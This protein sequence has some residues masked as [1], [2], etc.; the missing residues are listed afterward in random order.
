[1]N[2]SSLE[3]EQMAVVEEKPACALAGGSE[4]IAELKEAGMTDAVCLKCGAM[5]SGAFTSCPQ[6]H[7]L[8]WNS[9]DKDRHIMASEFFLSRTVLEDISWRVRNGLPVQFEDRE[10]DGFVE[11]SNTVISEPEDNCGMLFTILSAIAIVAIVV[12]ILHL[13]PA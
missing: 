13:K 4:P 8:P 9:E 11:T 10:A 5:K 12:T 7:H 3:V 1:M 6:C 2:Q